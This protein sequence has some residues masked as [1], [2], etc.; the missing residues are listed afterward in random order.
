MKKDIFTGL[1]TALVTPFKSN[2]IDFDALEKI[3]E[4]Q[5]QGGVDGLV[6]VGTTGES[7]T[8]SFDEH[9]EIVKRVIKLVNKRVKVVP[10]TGANSTEEA[11]H[12]T[13]A[14]Q[15]YGADGA[16]LVNPYYNK[17]TQRGLI[18]HFEAV[19]KSVSIPIILYNIPGRTSVNFLPESIAELLKR[20]DNISAI[21]EASGDIAQMMKVIE[22][23]GDSMTLLSGD[24]NF[25]LPVLAIG[26]KG[27]ISVLSNF[28]PADLK[29]VITLF[30][31]QKY[32]ESREF[33]YKMLP[34]MRDIFIET[35]PIPVKAVMEI[36]GYCSS[37][38]RLPLVELSPENRNTLKKSL[39]A[40]GL[41]V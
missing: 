33:F 35:N 10:G 17:P 36:L 16:L 39:I 25:L 27:V 20:V 7:P 12:L 22:L 19:A 14:A 2:K 4:M 31:E 5:I 8:V 38:V 3:I 40:Y 29:K 24:D 30:N 15:D 21:K 11:I 32:K 41:K 6:P 26:G 37:S 34:I 9:K 28:L 1:Y 23:C 18:A 13:K